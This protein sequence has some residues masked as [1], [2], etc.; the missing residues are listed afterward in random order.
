[1]R[2]LTNVIRRLRVLHAANYRR[3]TTAVFGALQATA[4]NTMRDQAS[5]A[6]TFDAGNSQTCIAKQNLLHTGKAFARG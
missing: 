2:Q 5:A 4:G 6:H 1:M 3:L